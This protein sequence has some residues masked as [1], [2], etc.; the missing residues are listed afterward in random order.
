MVCD[1]EPSLLMPRKISPI[2]LVSLWNFSSNFREKSGTKIKIRKRCTLDE[3]PISKTMQ[4]F[5]TFLYREKRIKSKR[6]SPAHI[7]DPLSWHSKAVF[8]WTSEIYTT[9]NEWDG[10]LKDKIKWKQVFRMLV[11]LSH[12]SGVLGKFENKGR[13]TEGW[14]SE[15]LGLRGPWG[16]Q[17]NYSASSSEHGSNKNQFVREWVRLCCMNIIYPCWNLDKMSW[18]IT[19]PLISF[20][21]TK[22]TS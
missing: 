20:W 8:P 11:A 5:S 6:R 1:P 16:P 12:L 2:F 13:R 22:K 4:L 21:T 15:E 18:S 14:A 10:K 3:H 17:R 19:L 9:F 7:N